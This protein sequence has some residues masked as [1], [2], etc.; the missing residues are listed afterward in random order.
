MELWCGKVCDKFPSARI[1]MNEGERFR[2]T[3]APQ[4]ITLPLQ[5]T[6]KNDPCGSNDIEP[7]F[8]WWSKQSSYGKSVNITVHQSRVD[9]SVAA[10]SRLWTVKCSGSVLV[11]DESSTNHNPTLFGKR[12]SKSFLIQVLQNCDSIDTFSSITSV[13]FALPSHPPHKWVW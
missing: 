12:E 9:H 3:D 11:L 1:W 13:V 5:R 6:H 10:P 8:S 7:G 4:Y 2:S